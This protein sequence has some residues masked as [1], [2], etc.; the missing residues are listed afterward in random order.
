MPIEKK[1][2]H[3]TKDNVD[4]EGDNYGVYELGDTD[5]YVIYI[6][7]GRLY[8]RLISHFIGASHTI[9]GTKYY[10]VE[11]RNSKESAEQG[12]RRLLREHERNWDT[13]PKYNKRLG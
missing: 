9:P 6:G 1:W 8:T 4:R 10:R 5:G 12:E 3:F 13:L 2:S 11:Y 7:Q